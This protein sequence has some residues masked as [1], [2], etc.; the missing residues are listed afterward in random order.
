M[1]RASVVVKVDTPRIR[2]LFD[3]DKYIFF[4]IG[5]SARPTPRSLSV[6][7]RDDETMRVDVQGGDDI[8]RIDDTG[9]RD[10]SKVW[11]TC[12]FQLAACA[13]RISEPR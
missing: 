9:S 3:R 1:R 4:R 13:T 7:G 10:S 6:D 11:C 5:G 8:V 12:S 2:K